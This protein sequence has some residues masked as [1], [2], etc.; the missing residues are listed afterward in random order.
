MLSALFVLVIYFLL[1]LISLAI[2]ITKANMNTNAI[3]PPKSIVC[4]PLPKTNDQNNN[5]DD[6]QEYYEHP[7]PY[8]FHL[9]LSS[10]LFVS[11]S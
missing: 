11:A 3:F 10:F 9:I 8:L 2:K 1:F 7:I 4:T 6:P 5:C